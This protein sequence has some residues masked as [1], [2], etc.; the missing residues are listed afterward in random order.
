MLPS[1]PAE[2]FSQ[3]RAIE[4]MDTIPLQKLVQILLEMNMYQV[5]STKNQILDMCQSIIEND[6]LY[7]TLSVQAISAFRQSIEY[8]Q[9]VIDELDYYKT[10][11]ILYEEYNNHQVLDLCEELINELY[12]YIS[13]LEERIIRVM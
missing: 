8:T 9:G 7:E 1:L 10:S 5:G 11:I 3:L 4:N 13:R 6:N 12:R 2:A